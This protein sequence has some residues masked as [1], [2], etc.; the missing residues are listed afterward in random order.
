MGVAKG[1]GKG[2]SFLPVAVGGIKT[3][4]L[5]PGS[6]DVRVGATSGDNSSAVGGWWSDTDYLYVSDGGSQAYTFHRFSNVAIPQGATITSVKFQVL[7]RYLSAT[8]TGTD[9]LLVGVEPSANAGTVANASNISSR[10]EALSGTN[11]WDISSWT[12]GV[13]QEFTNLVVAVQAAV[14]LVSWAGDH[15]A[16]LTRSKN[17][18]AVGVQL[19]S[20]PKNGGN[21]NNTSRLLIDYLY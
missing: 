8:P 20:G 3:T 2:L 14:N 18:A 19:W 17:I 9:A 21:V 10:F 5:T 6:I 1:L 4:P 15:L 11:E 12:G 13:T 16:I 7:P